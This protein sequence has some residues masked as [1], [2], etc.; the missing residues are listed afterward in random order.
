MDASFRDPL[1]ADCP[2]VWTIPAVSRATHERPKSHR[3]RDD[4]ADAQQDQRRHTFEF[5]MMCLFYS[6]I[7]MPVL[8]GGGAD[9]GAAGQ[10]PARDVSHLAA[11]GANRFRV[12]PA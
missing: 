12:R 5:F 6:G 8:G 3:D 11:S 7:V 1:A 10:R 9:A 4:A 2:E